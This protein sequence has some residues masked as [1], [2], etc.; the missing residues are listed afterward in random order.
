MRARELA[1]QVGRLLD[2]PG[3]WN[4]VPK[5]YMVEKTGASPQRHPFT[6]TLKPH[7]E[8]ARALTH[9]HTH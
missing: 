4:S 1:K 6:S 8:H 2:K 7:P 3:N 5:S 9:M